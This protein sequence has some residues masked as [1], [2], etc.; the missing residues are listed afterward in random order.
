MRLS[1][2]RLPIHSTTTTDRTVRSLLASK[3]LHEHQIESTI[4][5]K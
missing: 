5:L 4:K 3:A 1:Q 2:C